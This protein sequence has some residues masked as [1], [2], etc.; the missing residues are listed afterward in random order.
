MLAYINSFLDKYE[1]PFECKKEVNESFNILQKE[2]KI[3]ELTKLINVYQINTQPSFKELNTL[4][5]EFANTTS[6]HI[7]EIWLI[8]FILM[9]KPLF[10]RYKQLNYS[11]DMFTYAMYDI[12]YKAIECSLVKKM[13]GNFVPSWEYGFFTFQLYGFNTLQFEPIKADKNYQVN[14]V[15]IKKGETLLSVHIPRREKHLDENEVQH[16]FKL[17]MEF[18]KNK[19]DHLIFFCHSWLLLPRNKEMLSKDSHLRHFIDLFTIIETYEAPNYSEMWRLFDMEIDENNLDA[20]PSNTSFRRAYI[21]LMK[22]KE[23]TG[24]GVGI[25]IPFPVLK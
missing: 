1:F 5:E 6:V 17:A 16:D 22:N 14:G 4:V 25:Y 8:I 24:G 12:K 23:K 9:S 10:E 7:Y 21:Q 19:V 18:F 20:L 11:E 3:D 13:W 15:T 2:A